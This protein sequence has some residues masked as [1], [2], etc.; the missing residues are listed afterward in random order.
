MML[1]PQDYTPQRKGKAKKE[2]PPPYLGNAQTVALALL[3]ILE[4]DDQ[5]LLDLYL[6]QP[7]S[8]WQDPGQEITLGDRLSHCVVVV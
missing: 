6:F 2:T 4:L 7:E 3:A 8:S 1:Q 5:N